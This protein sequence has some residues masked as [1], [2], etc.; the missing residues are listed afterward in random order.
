MA[1]EG[2][3]WRSASEDMDTLLSYPVTSF[4]SCS[5]GSDT[6][7]TG[8]V[9]ERGGSLSTLQ[10]DANGVSGDAVVF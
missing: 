3:T 5:S 6:G 1:V 8:I 10:D 2:S 9:P 7:T 4:G